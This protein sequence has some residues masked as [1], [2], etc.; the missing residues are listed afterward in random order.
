MIAGIDSAFPG[1]KRAVYIFAVYVAL[2]WTYSLATTPRGG[3]LRNY[4]VAQWEKPGVGEN[5]KHV[6]RGDVDHHHGGGH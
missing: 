6:S 2:D 3:S 5:P 1:F 4:P